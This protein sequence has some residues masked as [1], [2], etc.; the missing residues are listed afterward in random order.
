MALALGLAACAGVHR[1]VPQARSRVAVAWDQGQAE[2][3][4][5]PAFAQPGERLLFEGR[6]L[7][8]AIGRVS[9]DVGG[10]R[11]VRGHRVISGRSV[12]ESDGMSA[13][14]SSLWWQ[15]DSTIDL[16]TGRPLQATDRWNI[17]FGGER[18]H[19]S[20]N[21]SS[22]DDDQYNLHSAVAAIRG[23]DPAPGER[24]RLRVD[25][26]GQFTIELASAGGEYLPAYGRAALR[27]E[28][29][30]LIGETYGFTFWI[31]DDAERIPLRLDM[32]THW[33]RVS[34]RLRRY[35]PP[36]RAP[37]RFGGDP[38]LL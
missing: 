15:L 31:S 19:G 38:A 18:D 26:G 24:R 5:A 37:R 8:V 2:P 21:Q 34:L 35:E 1:P 6:W 20:W 4:H 12:A 30:A 11:T 7:G 22:W 9:V 36:D 16:D 29:R 10:V 13:V 28:G 32:Q 27:Y 3:L 17:L 25:I 33:G 14:F 23:W